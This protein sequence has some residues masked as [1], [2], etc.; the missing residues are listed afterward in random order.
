[1]PNNIK[2]FLRYGTH[3]ES[4]YF[5]MSDFRNAYDAIIFNGNMVAYTPSAIAGFI[6]NIRDKP[7]IIDP[8]TH[9]FQHDIYKLT[10]EDESGNL[11]P[12]RS[13]QRLADAFG[14]PVKEIVGIESLLPEDINDKKIQREFCK[15]VINFQLDIKKHIELKPEWKY[16][17]FALD[18]G[19]SGENI[20]SPIA[21]IPPYF[22]MTAN[23]IDEWLDTNESFI[24]IAKEEFPDKQIYAQLVISKDILVVPAQREKITKR[25]K[26][27][28]A[29]G[30]LLWV[31][32]LEEATAG[33][34]C[35][36][37]YIK[38]ITELS[39]T[40]KIINLYG[41]YLSILLIKE[42]RLEG[43]CHGLEYGESRGVVPVGGGIP[44]S[45]YYFYP[46]HQ[47]IRFTDFLKI[48]RQ[49]KM[50]KEEFRAKICRC[51]VCV[52]G[53]ISKYG[54]THPVKYKRGGQVITLN[55]PTPEAKDYSLRHYLSSK[56][57]EFED[58]NSKNKKHILA[59]L[60]NA[61]NEYKKVLGLDEVIYLDVWKNLIEKL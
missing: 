34:E 31:D 10:H 23:T 11:I 25:Y 46:L 47:R 60:E 36:D 4:K 56:K 5:L 50:S 55:Y 26:D 19:K 20:F 24:K 43:V 40:K 44:M 45:K 9:A 33:G 54:I 42:G 15:N 57:R 61:F 28:S 52:D 53:N 22:Y 12:K 32:G 39:V 18:N 41:G 59:E 1:M 21:V 48:I 6:V 35:L 37:C 51:D 3:A 17:K 29:D 38:L 27:V 58:V 13:I 7:F 16:L 2:H 8:Q 14:S 30:I 49:K